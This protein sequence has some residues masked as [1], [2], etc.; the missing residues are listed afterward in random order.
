MG[1]PH[2]KSSWD[3]KTF[4]LRY[5]IISRYPERLAKQCV[6][7]VVIRESEIFELGSGLPISAYKTPL[8]NFYKVGLKF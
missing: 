6:F 8:K 5:R 3:A 7:S 4:A 1:G 2:Q